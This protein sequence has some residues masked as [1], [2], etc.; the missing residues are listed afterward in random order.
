MRMNSIPVVLEV[1]RELL[2]WLEDSGS[3]TQQVSKET[4]PQQVKEYKCY[5]QASVSADSTLRF[6][7]KGWSA[8]NIYYKGHSSPIIVFLRK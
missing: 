7:Y 2:Y 8:T 1:T 4:A 3:E 6:S 5:R